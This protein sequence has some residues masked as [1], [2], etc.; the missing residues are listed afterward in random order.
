MVETAPGLLVTVVV[1][2]EEEARMLRALAAKMAADG[3]P[4][5]LEVAIAPAG[6]DLP[7]FD[8]G[9]LHAV[10]VG[11]FEALPAA[12]VWDLRGE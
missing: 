2:T 12:A 11:Q 9:E 7:G 1:E 5:S 8:E 4:T 10:E 6:V 3:R